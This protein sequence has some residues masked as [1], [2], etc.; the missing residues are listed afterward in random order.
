MNPNDP[1]GAAGALKTPLALIPPFAMEQAAFIWLH[2]QPN[3]TDE[4]HQLT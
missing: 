3:I 2:S 4:E 1:K